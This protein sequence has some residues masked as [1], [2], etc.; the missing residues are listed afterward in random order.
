MKITVQTLFKDTKLQK[1]EVC[2]GKKETA[3]NVNASVF[4]TILLLYFS[5]WNRYL[6]VPI[7]IFSFMYLYTFM[8]M[9]LC[10]VILYY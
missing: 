8:H 7:P 9:L 3:C 2:E 1:Q 10:I 4:V 6:Y 5:V